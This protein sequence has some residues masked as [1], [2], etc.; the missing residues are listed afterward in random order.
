MLFSQLC[1]K[2]VVSAC[3]GERLGY[4]DDAEYDETTGEVLRFF[5]YGRG[6]LFGLLGR[7]EDVV[8]ERGDIETVGS[9][10]ILVRRQAKRAPGLPR[11]GRF[12]L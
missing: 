9:D 10:I 8:V 5:I 12:G 4:V 7:S 3:D 11:R 6:E 1:E 2:E